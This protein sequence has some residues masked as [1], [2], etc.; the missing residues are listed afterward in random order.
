MNIRYSF[1][2]IF[3]LLQGNQ[4]R[5]S[6]LKAEAFYKEG[7]LEE[8]LDAYNALAYAS[9]VVSYNRGL[10]YDAMH[11][12]SKALYAFRQA[13]KHADYRLLKKIEP[14]IQAL[15]DRLHIPH[16][17]F[18]YSV[19]CALQSLFSAWLVQ[20]LFLLCFAIFIFLL[21]FQR[22]RGLFA[23]LILFGLFV[24]GMLT[25]IHYWFASQ[26]YAVV[27]QEKVI[28]FAGP[29]KEFHTIGDILCGN[30]VKV[31]EQDRSW[32]KV[33]FHGVQ[34]WVEKSGLELII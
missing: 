32:Y 8:A 28:L 22:L 9:A 31:V 15:Q 17:S 20:M 27:M 18:W 12:D 3:T 16:D 23:L 14:R 4:D 33:D 5:E 13:Q 19:A 2:I 25:G 26:Q 21:W 34:G 29:Q 1:L 24:T 7:K 6:F 30:E 11:Q 10:C